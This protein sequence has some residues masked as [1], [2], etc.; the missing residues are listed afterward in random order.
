M[1]KRRI[2]PLT[3]SFQINSIIVSC[4]NYGIGIPIW[5]FEMSAFKTLPSVLTLETVLQIILCDQVLLDEHVTASNSIPPWWCGV[6][7]LSIPSTIVRETFQK[8]C[9]WTRWEWRG[10]GEQNLFAQG[11]LFSLQSLL[12]FDSGST[13]PRGDIDLLE[14]K[15]APLCSCT[16][17]N[18]NTN[19]DTHT[20][21]PTHTKRTHGDTHA[22][23]CQSVSP[24]RESISCRILLAVWQAAK[25]ICY[26]HTHSLELIPLPWCMTT[27]VNGILFPSLLPNINSDNDKAI[28]LKDMCWISLSICLGRDVLTEM[29][30]KE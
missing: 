1:K 19:T 21:T 27:D 2:G 7:T 6:S 12:L 24:S 10:L 16:W 5:M 20:H 17:E 18:T 29:G 4:F 25:N 13:F 11:S 28:A 14:A 9:E 30:K 3:A 23:T 8:T 15:Q 26:T 22:R